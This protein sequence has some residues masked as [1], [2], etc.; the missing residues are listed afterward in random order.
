MMCLLYG[1]ASD[2]APLAGISTR[3][4][5][6][7]HLAVLPPIACAPAS[8][9]TAH[10]PPLRYADHLWLAPCIGAPDRHQHFSLPGLSLYNHHRFF[11]TF[12]LEAF[13]SCVRYG[14]SGPASQ[15][16]SPCTGTT[17]ADTHKSCGTCDH[18]HGVAI[19]R[20]R[21]LHWQ[22]AD[23]TLVVCICVTAGLPL[24]AATESQCRATA[25]TRLNRIT[26]SCTK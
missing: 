11:L 22:V 6:S 19:I 14:V 20:P 7:L 25:G 1:Y 8:M 2:S 10:L 23:A 4:A 3:L 21:H 18:S 9:F 24:A 12:L 26:H 15:A 16:P 17:P 5:P 13:A